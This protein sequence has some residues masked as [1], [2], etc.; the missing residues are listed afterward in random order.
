MDGAKSHPGAGLGGGDGFGWPSCWMRWPAAWPRL[1][2]DE[3]DDHDRLAASPE[4]SRGRVTATA[5]L[6]ATERRPGSTGASLLPLVL[7][8]GDLSIVDRL[9]APE[10]D[11]VVDC[12]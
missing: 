8:P 6:Q 1:E 5:R 11:S 7:E 2:G 10:D 12:E 4:T 9:V 3:R